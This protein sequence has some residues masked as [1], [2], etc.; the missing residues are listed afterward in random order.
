M[1][2]LIETE[3]PTS[4]TREPLYLSYIPT[5]R[6]FLESG[7]RCAEVED[8][9]D[10]Q[11]LVSRLQVAVDKLDARGTVKVRTRSV[12]GAKHVYLTREDRVERD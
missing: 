2:K 11:R 4:Y 8:E 7:M 5:V 6:N 12:D 1:T 3:L 10:A 9:L